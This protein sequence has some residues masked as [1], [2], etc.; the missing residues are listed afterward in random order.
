[1]DKLKQRWITIIKQTDTELILLTT[2]LL[3]TLFLLQSKG[4][5]LER[6]EDYDVFDNERPIEQ[7]LLYYSKNV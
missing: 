7:N 6:L 4:W 1:M 3:N 5:R 2:R